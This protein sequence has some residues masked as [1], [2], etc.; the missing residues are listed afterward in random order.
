MLI[1]YYY[2]Y[3]IIMQLHDLSCDHGLFSREDLLWTI[4]L[5]KF[6]MDNVSSTGEKVCV[7]QF[8][9]FLFASEGKTDEGKDFTMGN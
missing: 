5:S 1:N 6:G 8:F 3:Y 4:L 9:F 2:Y 7:F